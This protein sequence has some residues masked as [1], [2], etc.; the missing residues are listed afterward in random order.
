MG[1]KRKPENSLKSEPSPK[2]RRIS[3]ITDL[4]RAQDVLCKYRPLHV[5]V[6]AS[7]NVPFS[8]YLVDRHTKQERKR[9]QPLALSPLL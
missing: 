6:T 4:G 2:I 5:T 1:S 8:Q 9:I 7:S 3:T